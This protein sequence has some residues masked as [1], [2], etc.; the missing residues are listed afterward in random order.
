M[1]RHPKRPARG[2]SRSNADRKRTDIMNQAARL[3]D[4]VGYHRTTMEDIAEAVGIRK[5]TLYHYFSGKADILFVIHEE[6]ID[7]L[8][9]R[10]LARGKTSLS[11]QQQLLGIIEDILDFMQTQRGHLRAFFEHYREL[12]K[13]YQETIRRKRRRY[14]DL[15]HSV[16]TSGMESGAFRPLNSRVTTLAIFGMCNWVYQWYDPGGA[17]GARDIAYVFWDL[18]SRGVDN[19][20]VRPPISGATSVRRLSGEDSLIEGGEA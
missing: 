9:E 10:Q 16:V 19:E 6:I 12:P 11:A 18:A 7:L 20:R 3:F 2:V 13:K 4:N 14:F 15:V 5:P 17:L 8:I 1:N